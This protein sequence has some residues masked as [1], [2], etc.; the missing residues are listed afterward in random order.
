MN[1]TPTFLQPT[2]LYHLHAYVLPISDL[3]IT[4]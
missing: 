3:F 1:I 4:Y 2:F